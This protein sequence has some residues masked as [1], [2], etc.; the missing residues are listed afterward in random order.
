MIDYAAIANAGGIP[1]PQP[2]KK[3]S[4]K[5]R[6]NSTISTNKGLKRTVHPVAEEVKKQALE[7]STFCFAGHC[8]VCGGN[9]VTIADDPHHMPHRSQGGRDIP[10]HIWMARRVCHGYMHDHPVE[11]RALFKR[12]EAAGFPVDWGTKV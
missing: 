4:G 2:K 5:K 9:R 8:P 11:E 3:P 7:K 6:K 12:I 10:E 1:K